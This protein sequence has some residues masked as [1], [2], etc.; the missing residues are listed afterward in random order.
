M[1]GAITL[2][3]ADPDDAATVHRFICELA[4]YER[5]PDAVQVTPARLEEQL[6][7]TRCPFECLIAEVDGEPAGFALWFQTY[8]TWRGR[9][10]LWL[11]DLYVTPDRRGIGVGAAL[12]DELRR[13]ARVRGY[14]RL[15]LGVLDWNEPA[16]GFYR[17]RGGR[18]LEG[19]T[20]YRFSP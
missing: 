3:A 12:F 13:V 8:S 10:G 6:A 4:E 1:A 18:P 9:P 7:S 20:Y 2:R 5:E 16:I 14:A 15:E 19:W 17:A 11:E